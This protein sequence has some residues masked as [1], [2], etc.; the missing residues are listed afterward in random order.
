LELNSDNIEELQMIYISLLELDNY[1]VLLLSKMETK[2]AELTVLKES[3][4]KSYNFKA[5]TIASVEAHLLQ[6]Y[7]R[8]L[9]QKVCNLNSTIVKNNE[10]DSSHK[11]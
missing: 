9:S 1:D 11:N 6:E 5:A 2:I 4:T 10:L 7:F 8:T 3:A